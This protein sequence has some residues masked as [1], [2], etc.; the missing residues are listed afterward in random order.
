MAVSEA[1]VKPGD[2]QVMAAGT[3]IAWPVT[4]M[5]VDFPPQAEAAAGG[6]A[7][8]L[9]LMQ[10]GQTAAC[11]LRYASYLAGCLAARSHAVEEW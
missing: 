5:C 10:C 7:Y 11:A 2:C 9:R 1:A 8:G 6:L 4:Y 3:H